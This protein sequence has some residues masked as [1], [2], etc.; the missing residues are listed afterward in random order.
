MS[1]TRSDKEKALDAYQA[2][3]AMDGDRRAFNLLLKRWHP[4]FLRLSYYLT[5]HKEDAEDVLQDALLTIA[6]NIGRLREPEL[7]GSWACTIIRRRAA[8]KI[9]TATKHR[10]TAKAITELPVLASA[11]PETGLS[12]KQILES[13]SPQDSRLMRL[14]YVAGFTADEIGAG[15]GIPPG[16]VKSRLFHIRKKLQQSV[17]PKGDQNVKF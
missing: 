10:R 14:S 5:G 17:N 12:L 11:D 8:D 13:L 15:L 6:K 16:T 9:K 2:I 1:T 7:F 4:R 3:L